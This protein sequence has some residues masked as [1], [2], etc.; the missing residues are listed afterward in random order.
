MSPLTVSNGFR[1]VRHVFLM[2][3]GLVLVSPSLGQAQSFEEVFTIQ[4]S[5]ELEQGDD[6]FLSVPYVS[7]LKDGGMLIPSAL[8]HYTD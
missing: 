3:V 8:N 5:L 6:A 7:L 2:L 1:A 4:N